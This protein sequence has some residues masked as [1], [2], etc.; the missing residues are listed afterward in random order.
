V[1]LSTPGEYE[2]L[3]HTDN[4]SDQS[5]HLYSLVVSFENYPLLTD[6]SYSETTNQFTLTVVRPTCDCGELVWDLPPIKTFTTGMMTNPPDTF[7]FD[8][9]TVDPASK[10]ASAR[11]RECYRDFGN[12]VETSSITVVDI[13]TGVLDSSL[14]AMAGT[15]L[16]LT[17]DHFGQ[18]RDIGN[19][20]VLRVTQTV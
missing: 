16:T 4:E 14:M 19:P 2:I 9:A 11:I 18:V 6:P 1:T 17:P 5:I 13:T 12:C 8:K 15:T 7:E 10:E 3:A 20:Y